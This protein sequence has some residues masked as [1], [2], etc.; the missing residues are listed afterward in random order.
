MLCR[1]RAEVSNDCSTCRNSNVYLVV[2]F[3]MR[4][5]V[6]PRIESPPA[7]GAWRGGYRYHGSSAAPGFAA[8]G[9][10]SAARGSAEDRRRGAP[11]EERTSFDDCRRQRVGRDIRAKREVSH[12]IR[13]HQ[14]GGRVTQTLHRS[15]GWGKRGAPSNTNRVLVTAAAATCGQ[16]RLIAANCG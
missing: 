13:R 12:D 2:V 14:K 5:I 8:P 9:F 10:R 7:C 4:T 6:R 3:C 11:D 16:S 15:K 1:A